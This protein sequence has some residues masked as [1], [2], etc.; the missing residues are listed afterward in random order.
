MPFQDS[1]AQG[2]LCMF[3]PFYGLFYVLS[4]FEECKRP[5]FL[6]LGAVGILGVTIVLGGGVMRA[7]NN[8]DFRAP[9]PKVQFQR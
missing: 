7:N 1:A 8:N 3:V 9:P 5:F 2:L 4:H 6:Q